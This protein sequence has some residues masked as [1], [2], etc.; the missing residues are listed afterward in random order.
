[1]RLT[2]QWTVSCFH[3]E[4]SKKVKKRQLSRHHGRNFL[5]PMRFTLFE[6]CICCYG[7]ALALLV[8]V[9]IL[10]SNCYVCSIIAF[11][12]NNSLDAAWPHPPCKGCGLQDYSCSRIHAVWTVVPRP[13]HLPIFDCVQFSILV[14][15]R[16]QFYWGVTINNQK[17]RPGN[18]VV[19]PCFR[20]AT[21]NMTVPS[22]V[23]RPFLYGW[24]ERGAPLSH[25]AHTRRVWEPN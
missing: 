9:R 14:F 21:T 22:M 23:P 13:S 11:L 20:C 2:K 10:L 4:E 19:N 8:D 7:A 16:V 3:I 24:G 6:D 18:E 17:A 1:M 12:S 15:D 5:W 25:P